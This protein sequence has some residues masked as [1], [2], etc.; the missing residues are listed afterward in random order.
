MLRS[1]TGQNPAAP[2]SS[3]GILGSF[4]LLENYTP[5]KS[6]LKKRKC[7]EEFIL[8]LMEGEYDS[9][10]VFLPGRALLEDILF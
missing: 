10:E 9:L 3:N 4:E 8:T 6:I 7:S 5:W 1:F 2:K